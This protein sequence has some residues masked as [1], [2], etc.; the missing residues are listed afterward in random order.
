L[1]IEE[2]PKFVRSVAELQYTNPDIAAFVAEC[3]ARDIRY[4]KLAAADKHQVKK[5]G[6]ST[7]DD[8]ERVHRVRKDERAKMLDNAESFSDSPPKRARDTRTLSPVHRRQSCRPNVADLDSSHACSHS[9]PRASSRPS[10]DTHAL[11]PLC[12]QFGTSNK[13]V[14]MYSQVHAEIDSG[15]SMTMTPR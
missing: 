8:Q 13:V 10:R 9:A 14:P 4:E 11:S 5:T 15:A 2:V 6:E 1:L 3:D 12:P 7:Q